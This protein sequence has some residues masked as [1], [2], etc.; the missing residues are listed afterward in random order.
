MAAEKMETFPL[1]ELLPKLHSRKRKG[2][3][4]ERAAGGE[5]N[6]HITFNASS[7]VGMD[8]S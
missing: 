2:I 8:R 3:E 5:A 1:P 6:F 4:R 7:I